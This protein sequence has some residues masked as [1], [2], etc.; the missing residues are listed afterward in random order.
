[1]SFGNPLFL[2]GLLAVPVPVLL[3]LF[4]RRRKA[5]IAFSTLQFFHQRKRYLAHRRRLREILLLLIRTLALLGL[6]L[7]LAKTRFQS[8]PASF[9]VR[10]NAA[11]L[12]DDTLSMD[13]KLSSGAT[14]FELAVQKAD[15]IL[16]TL[17]DGDAAALSFLSGRRG[18]ALTR[19]RQAVRQLLEAS[20]VTGATGSYS[21]GL[22]QALTDLASDGNPNREIFVLSD[23]QANQAPSRPISLGNAQGLRIYFLPIGGNT[24]NLSVDNVK[25][26]TRPQT[27]RKSM[28]IPYEI[29]NHGDTPCEADV[30]L[31]IGTET[32]R[33]ETVSVPAGDAAKGRFEYVPTHA[34]FL[35]GSVQVSDRQLELDNRRFFTVNVS[36]NIRAL[37]LESDIRSRVR[38]FHFLK[39]AVDPAD[40]QAVNGIQ[41]DLGFIQ[42]LTPK[43]LENYHVVVLANPQP[44]TAQTADMLTRYMERGGSVLAFAGGDVTTATFA[45]FQNENVRKLFGA[46][47]PAA[48]SGLSF[49]GALAGLNDLLQLDLVKWQ[50]LHPLA[51]SPSATVLA[52]NRGRVMIAEERI[53]AGGFIACAFSLRRDAGNWPELK[54]F[55]IA[56]IHLL[57]YAAHD[58]QQNA[59]VTC[60]RLLRLNTLAA[61]GKAVALRHSDGLRF[62]ILAEKGEAVFDDTWQP[63]IMTAEQAAPRS[64]AINP[65]PSESVLAQMDAGK[66]ADMVQGKVSIL[67]T[68]AAIDTQVRSYRQ[69]SD[70]TGMLLFLVMLLLLSETLLGNT[71]LARPRIT[72]Q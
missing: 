33:T 43:V 42:E 27:V 67:K 56:M 34:G 61:D 57:T 1:M 8:L 22:Q 37:L 3:H 47:D 38:P 41:T 65:A 13:R 35:S 20:R 7:A 29:R 52:E 53:G 39:L 26:S 2:W 32:V 19:K 54:S 64:V 21:A 59:A 48:V 46:R 14:A 63:G 17:A 51:P 5:N 30:R 9:A 60:G 62:Q 28:T 49:K 15:E 44:L 16:N 68:D 6:V 45:A 18:I 31:V 55:P 50:R 58:P 23:F 11:I 12:L 69:G 71:Y 24:E 36:E 70:L 25:L 4:F 40:G 72:A 66:L 10:T